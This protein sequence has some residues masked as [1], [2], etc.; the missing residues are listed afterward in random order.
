MIIWTQVIAGHR[1]ALYRD[2]G[3]DKEDGR[4]TYGIL[5]E[6]NTRTPGHLFEL[7]L[8]T[9]GKTISSILDPPVP[10]DYLPK[11]KKIRVTALMKTC[12]LMYVM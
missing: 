4:L 3:P 6:S 9:I 7:S 10:W 8:N 2:R 5:D 11:M 12:R 1:I